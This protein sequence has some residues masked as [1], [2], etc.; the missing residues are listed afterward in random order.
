MLGHLMQCQKGFERSRTAEL[1]DAAERD[2]GDG[3]VVLRAAAAGTGL[4]GMLQPAGDRAAG[5]AAAS[6]GPQVLLDLHRKRA[7]TPLAKGSP[8]PRW[9]NGRA[10]CERRVLLKVFRI[11][12]G[13]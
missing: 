5:D 1:T 13:V 12:V 10:S 4:L 3:N 8:A 9:R 11:Y 2:R 6:W 7:N